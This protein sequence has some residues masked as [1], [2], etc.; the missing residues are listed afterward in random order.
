MLCIGLAI[1]LVCLPGYNLYDFLG[2]DIKHMGTHVKS[3]CNYCFWPSWVP[4]GATQ[5]SWWTDVKLMLSYGEACIP[6][7][8]LAKKNPSY[9]I[10]R[11]KINLMQN[12]LAESKIL[13]EWQHH[14]KTFFM[15]LSLS[16]TAF[17]LP[18]SSCVEACWKKQA[19][20]P[21]Q[22]LHPCSLY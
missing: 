5:A 22:K 20:L 19:R 1:N 10:T 14:F 17:E 3:S 18:A 15:F 8:T 21:A 12:T 6:V 11:Y 2:L 16:E 13:A 7:N 9:R 4:Y